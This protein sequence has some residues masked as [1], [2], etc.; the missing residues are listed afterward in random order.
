MKLNK[1]FPLLFLGMSLLALNLF[2]S[3]RAQTA[4]IKEVRIKIDA[5]SPLFFTE[6]I[7]NKLLIQRQDSLF[8]KQ[9]DVVDLSSVEAHF[10][11]IPT[12]KNVQ[13]YTNPQGSLHVDIQ[14]RKPLIRV[15]G[16]TSY[17]LDD[18]GKQIP[19]SS[20]RT[21]LVPLF[22]GQLDEQNAKS[23]V[24]LVVQMK[25]DDFLN[26]Q[27]VHYQMKNEQFVLGLRS[28][29]F[30]VVWGKNKDF[31]AKKQKLKRFCAYYN[32]HKDET[33]EEVSLIY[34]QQVVARHN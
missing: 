1:L 5:D 33:I 6:Q 29:P 23:I 9:K 25:E 10:S 26:Q 22:F 34:K 21:A 19:L 28:F 27:V 17:Y 24:D 32:A 30:D 20:L 3:Y 13:L 31:E 16:E 8:Y 2:S 18:T 12:I 7:V 15:N 11:R 14:E 4:K